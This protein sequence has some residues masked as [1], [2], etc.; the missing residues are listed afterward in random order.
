MS[1]NNDSLYTANPIY[2]LFL[3]Y[4]FIVA[5]YRK[6]STISHFGYSAYF[7]FKAN[8]V[9][10]YTPKSD[11]CSSS[12][13]SPQHLSSF[14]RSMMVLDT[15]QRRCKSFRD[16]NGRSSRSATIA[17]ATVSPKESIAKNG[18]NKAPS[19]MLKRLASEC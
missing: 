17:S 10:Y 4:N 7:V 5:K 8:L 13:S 16:V 11:I 12:G 2:S 14:I 18:G 19:L 3:I 15:L 1:N 6:I 9:F